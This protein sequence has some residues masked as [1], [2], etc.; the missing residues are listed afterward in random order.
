MLPMNAGLFGKPS[1][2]ANRPRMAALSHNIKLAA[3]AQGLVASDESNN[4]R[5]TTGKYYA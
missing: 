5:K 3:S 4:E 1:R 2:T